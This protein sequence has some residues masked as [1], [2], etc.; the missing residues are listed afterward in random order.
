MDNINEIARKFWDNE[1]RIE[2]V[3]NLSGSQYKTQIEGL[4]LTEY[5]NKGCTVMEVGVGLGYVTKGLYEAGAKVTAVDLSDIALKKVS[6][7]CEMIYTI[8]HLYYLPS[9]YF[10]VIICANVVQHIPT[11]QLIGEL[12]E[13]MRALKPGG[14]FAIEF[15]SSTT[16]ED[17]GMPPVNRDLIGGGF[18]RTPAY[19]EHILNLF[20]GKC[21]VIEDVKV[22]FYPI[23]GC[24]VFHVTK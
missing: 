16:C 10:D 23:T 12:K 22:D 6:K 21:T 14:V 11:I 4:K 20:G 5:I 1:H 15:V 9:N 2:N 19:M 17:N 8:D 13:F 7:Y 24:H 3:D 18:C